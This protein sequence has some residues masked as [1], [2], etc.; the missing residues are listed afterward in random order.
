M[1]SDKLSS[2]LKR[3][4]AKHENKAEGEGRREK[5]EGRRQKAQRQKSEAEKRRRGE[6]AYRLQTT[7]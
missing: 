4:R 3:A 7:D 6:I 1:F 2:P 5:A